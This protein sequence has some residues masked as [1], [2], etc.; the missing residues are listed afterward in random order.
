[1]KRNIIFT[2]IFLITSISFGQKIK[3]ITEWKK[4]EDSLVKTRIT[5][6]NKSGDLTKEIK[7][8]G[9]DAISGTYRNKNRYIKYKNGKRVSEYYCEDFVSKDTCVVRSI[10]TYE[11]NSETGVEKETKYEADSLI[12]FIREIKKEKQVTIS[13]THSWEFVPVKKPDYEKALVLTDTSYFDKMNRIIK[14][15]NYNS[16]SEKPFVEKYKYSKNK[17]SYQIIGA[18]KDTT[19]IFDYSKEQKK[20]DKQDIKYRFE[21][22]DKYRYEIEYYF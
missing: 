2:I 6:F 8:G 18:S 17:Y 21:A 16:R 20:I 10:A 11:F 1:M 22:D 14:R 4:E 19:M 5:E 13:K 12:R 7:Y 9:Y 15:V 3:T